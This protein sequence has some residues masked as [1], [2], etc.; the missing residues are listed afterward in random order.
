MISE[1]IC[2]R[3]FSVPT[4]FKFFPGPL[5]VQNLLLCHEENLI[6]IF[7]FYLSCFQDL[8]VHQPTTCFQKK[9]GSLQLIT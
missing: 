3:N 6:I 4:L 9:K 1:L 7:C 5:I 2:F 8:P